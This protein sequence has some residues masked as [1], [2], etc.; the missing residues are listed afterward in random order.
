MLIA[1][2]D[3]SH[4]VAMMP[5]VYPSYGTAT[6]RK[7]VVM[8]VMSLVW[9]FV[10]RESVQS[11]NSS[12]PITI[13]H[14]RSNSAMGRTI[15]AMGRMRL[16]VISHAILGCTSAKIAASA[17]QH[18]LHAMEMT[19]AETGVMKP[20][21]CART[22]V[23]IA[24]MKNSDVAITS[25]LRRRGN[26][27][28][29]MIAAMGR[30]SQPNVRRWSATVVGRGVPPRIGVSPTGLTAMARMIVVMGRMK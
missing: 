12:A 13:A 6:V 15:V 17:S 3:N 28:M 16:I 19:T 9:K 11:V 20:M 4:A 29:T 2:K 1:P 26:V 7:T 14:G 22:R 10:G 30:T 8:A 21:K 25:A 24:Q 5:S 27:T 23:G 18:G